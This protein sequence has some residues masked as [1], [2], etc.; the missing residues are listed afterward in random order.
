MCVCAL[1]S[2]AVVVCACGE[3]SRPVLYERCVVLC[4]A[5]YTCSKSSS[6]TKD[7]FGCLCRVRSLLASFQV[8]TSRYK[9]EY[10]E[11]IVS[12]LV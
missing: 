5:V 1:T 4:T 7:G 2:S 8:G 12:P 10:V 9:T 3:A 6:I 11:D